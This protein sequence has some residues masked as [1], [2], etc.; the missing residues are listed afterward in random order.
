MLVLLLLLQSRCYGNNTPSVTNEDVWFEVNIR[1]GR[2]LWEPACWELSLT[3]LSLSLFFSR[4]SLH[5]SD[6]WF[7]ISPTFLL[8]FLLLILPQRALYESEWIV[9][10]KSSAPQVLV[11]NSVNWTQIIIILR[12]RFLLLP[13]LNFLIS[14]T[15][16]NYLPSSPRQLVHTPTTAHNCHCL[17]AHVQICMPTTEY[18]YHNKVTQKTGM[19]LFQA[20]TLLE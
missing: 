1:K 8:L 13:T 16:T 6:F 19:C 20:H 11:I 10:N 4:S 5:Q 3:L 17:C 12:R 14:R 18:S 9:G 2:R 7:F 15:I